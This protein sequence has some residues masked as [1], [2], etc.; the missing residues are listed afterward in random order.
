MRQ[1]KVKK[2][3]GQIFFTAVIFFLVTMPFRYLFRLNGLTEIRPAGAFPPVFGLLIGIPGAIGCALGNFAADIMS[4]YPLQVCVWGIPAQFIYGCLSHWLWY[5][6]GES[7]DS[8]VR[9]SSV[10]RVLK[11]IVIVLLDTLLM[12]V[13][14]GAIQEHLKLGELLSQ[15]TLLLFF[16]NLAF[17]MILGV[18]MVILAGMAKAESRGM[19]LNLNVRFVLIFLLLSV[20]SGILAG[21]ISYKE[22]AACINDLVT[23]WNRIYMKVSVDFFVLCGIAVCFLWYLEKNISRP[24]EKLAEIARDYAD[25]EKINDKVQKEKKGHIESGH[26]IEQCDVLGRYHGEIGYLA[27]AFKKMMQDV[28]YYIS[29]LTVITKEKERIRTELDVASRIQADVLPD[30]SLELTSYKEFDI[31]ARMIP[32]KSVAGDFYDFFMIDEEHLAFLVADVSGKGIP[33][34][35]FMMVAKTLIHNQTQNVLSP[36]K[37]FED[38]NRTLCEKNKNGMF[39]TVW[40]GVL[41]LSDGK[42][43][44]AN[45]GHNTPLVQQSQKSYT[46]AL[47]KTGFVL[48]GIENAKYEQKQIQLNPGDTIFLYSDGITEANNIYKELYGEERLETL[49]NE[50]RHALPEELLSAVLENVKQYQGEAEQFDDITMLILRYNGDG[51]VKNTGTADITRMAEVVQ[52]AKQ[53]LEEKKVREETVNAV[54]IAMDEIFSNICYYSQAGKVTIGMKVQD[55][56]SGKQV[57][58]MYFEDDGIPFNPLKHDVP[59]ITE[60]VE[61]RKEG[62][63]GIYLVKNSMKLVD[64]KYSAGK[65]RLTIEC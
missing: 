35:L 8:V 19:V 36:A 54:Q 22:T 39:V 48:A 23:L 13:M 59:D 30:S 17:C 40:M 44:Y 61:T 47:D 51:Y 14:L 11:Y 33:A 65:N 64:Y 58:K 5:H 50:N 21:I 63:L 4:G 16:N 55:S 28:E 26:M 42:L 10:N 60:S 37:V 24:M 32:A 2:Y 27:M 9:L 57:V 62:G 12:A 49:V 20:A 7:K 25:K 34:S 6:R 1:I 31:R 53:N 41:A 45:A 15:S 29:N 56:D 43:V 46:Y 18:P 3:I 38:V 52:F